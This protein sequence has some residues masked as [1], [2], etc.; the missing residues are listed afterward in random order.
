VGGG[1]PGP[2][3]R[4][5]GSGG[6]LSFTSE[7]RWD[8]IFLSDLPCISEPC[9]R[10]KRWGMDPVGSL[11]GYGFCKGLYAAQCGTGDVPE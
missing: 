11:R 8:L 10:E 9:R 2:G 6:V 5:E 4:Y 3:V 7:K 1:D